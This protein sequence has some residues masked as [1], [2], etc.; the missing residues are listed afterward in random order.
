MRA[1]LHVCK[2]TDTRF[3]SQSG[4]DLSSIGADLFGVL[5]EQLEGLA[6]GVLA[7]LR[8]ERDVAADQALQARADG[9]DD[10][11]GAYGDA[12]DDPEAADDAVARKLECRGD[13]GVIQHV[14]KYMRDRR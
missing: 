9:P 5:G 1:P 14:G 2:W 11:S 8:P 6:A 3:R 10:A 12:P 7:E 4:F 13:E